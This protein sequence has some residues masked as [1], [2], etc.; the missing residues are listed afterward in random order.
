MK[1]LF[2]FFQFML[3]AINAVLAYICFTTDSPIIGS[4]SLGVSMT[5]ACLGFFYTKDYF[6][7]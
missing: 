1:L 6:S 4:L 2:A 7:N 3:S 5:T